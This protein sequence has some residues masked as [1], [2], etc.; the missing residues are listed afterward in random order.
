MKIRKLIETLLEDHELDDEIIVDWFSK[1][2]LTDWLDCGELDFTEQEFDK[3]WLAIQEKGQEEMGEALS[4]Y[5]AVYEIR[6]L[7]LDEIVE[8]RKVNV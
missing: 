1:K 7:V 3:A 2:F 6:T 4:H 8:S 5:G